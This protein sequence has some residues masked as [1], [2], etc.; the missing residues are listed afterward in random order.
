[1][2]T[3]RTSLCLALVVSGVASLASGCWLSHGRPRGDSDAG[4]ARLDAAMRPD[5]PPPDPGC[6]SP[7][8]TY[9]EPGCGSGEDVRI[10]AGCYQPCEG[11]T[12]ASCG[13]GR[14]CRRT[15]INPCI[16][17]PGGSCCGA[18][19]SERW[20]CLE[21]A[22]PMGC[23]GRSYCDC[24]EGCEPLVDLTHG[25]VCPCDEPFRCGGPPCDCICGGA[26]Y[27]GCA[28]AGACH[29]TEVTCGS[30]TLADL[31]SGCPECVGGI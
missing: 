15:D 26:R 27:L 16:C 17:T 5:A 14:A 8:E 11:P 10:T 13:P 31:V 19:G 29:P 21:P 1:M 22:P 12:D 23:E 4:S 2:T 25:C 30:D 28:A 6:L 24:T 18:C 7:R 3:L 9:F 20:L